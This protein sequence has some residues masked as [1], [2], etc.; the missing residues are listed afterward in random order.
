CKTF[1]KRANG[2]VRSEGIGAA[3]FKP[4]NKALA[5]G[6][7]IYAVSKV[8]AENHGGHATSLTAPNPQAQ[9]QLL[10]SA[11]EKAHFDPSTI[12]YIEAHGTGTSLGDPIE[13]NALKNAFTELYKRSGKSLPTQPHCG[14]GSVKT[15]M[16]H[17]ESAAGMAGLFKVLLAMK[18][19]ILPGNLHFTE[20]N[21]YLQLQESPFYI[22]TENRAWIPLTDTGGNKIPRRAGVSSFGFG[23]SNA[24]IVLE[25][26]ESKVPSMTDD[27]PQLMVLSAKNTERL[28][29][30]ASSMI[31]FLAQQSDIPL[32][33]IAYTLQVGREAMVDRLA[34]VVSSVDEFF[35]KL[36]QYIQ[37][38]TEKKAFYC[39][40]VKTNKTQSELLIEGEEGRDFVHSIIKNKK[41]SKLAQLWVSG[42]EI[43]WQLF[44]ENPKPQRI[45]LPTYAFAKER[46]WIST[47]EQS[48]KSVEG[49]KAKFDSHES[50]TQHTAKIPSKIDEQNQW[51]V[52]KLEPG[53][54]TPSGSVLLFETDD[55][56]EFRFTVKTKL[57]EHSHTIVTDS[58]IL[59]REH[60]ETFRLKKH[61]QPPKIAFLFT[62]QGSQYVG[63]GRELY[64]TQPI[65]RQTL[66]RCDDILRAYLEKPL[67][68][69]LYQ[70]ADA[71]EERKILFSRGRHFSLDETI[72]TQPAL[73][74]LEYALVALWKSWGIEPT[75][76]MGHSLGEYVAACVAGVF[77]LE[78][79]LKL[80]VERARLMQSLPQEGEMM[81]VLADE[82]QVLKACEPYPDAVSIA[83]INEP[84][85][86]VISG[87]SQ[88][89]QAVKAILEAQGIETYRLNISVG[90]HSP[91]MTAILAD[92][93]KITSEV[94]YS[95]PQ[96]DIISNLT[97]KL[98]MPEEITTP[99]YWCRHAQQTVRFAAGI[100]TLAT[101]GIEIFL[102]IGPQPTLIDMGQHCLPETGVWL[103][104]L[105]QWA[106]NWQQ[107]FQSVAKLYV[108]GASIDWAAF[109]QYYPRCRV[110]LPI[111]LTQ[112]ASATGSLLLFDIDKVRYLHFKERLLNEVILVMPGEGYQALEPQIYSINPNHPADY[113]KLL[114]NTGLPSHIIHIGS[115]TPFDEAVQNAQLEM[116]L[117]SCV[118]LS[119]T[120][121][122][123]KPV[124]PIFVLYA[125]LVEPGQQ[126]QHVSEF[127]KT[128][129]LESELI[130][131]KTVALSSFDQIVDIV[132]SEFQ[133]SDVEIRYDK[134][135]RWVKQLPDFQSAEETMLDSV[136]KS[137][138]LEKVQTDLL[139]MATTQLKLNVQQIDWSEPLRDYGFNSIAL[140]EFAIRINNQYQLE[141][142]PAVFLEYP[143]VN[144]FSQFLCSK[145]Q[146][147]LI[148]YY[149]EQAESTS[150]LAQKGGGETV[151]KETNT[152]S[153]L[154][155]ELV[156]INTSGHYQPS[157]W[158]HGILGFANDFYRLAAILGPDYPV[159][160]FQARGLDG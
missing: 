101:Q 85:N 4:L 56:S 23:G 153:K 77:S 122:Q 34:M 102:E 7:K 140:T 57:P 55:K 91:L 61:R 124:E 144:A 78:D 127:V 22:V 115:P 152:R 5:D 150:V 95:S 108:Q 143:S 106:S 93:E 6:D 43:D 157:F 147:H 46:Y 49:Q 119:Q 72:Y 45:S 100:E 105:Q 2:Y 87:Q 41:L 36:T 94:N 71:K 158:V 12:S 52:S 73:F 80:V 25:E 53:L 27:S 79:G 1:D 83:A 97:G 121:L 136:E 133:T 145:Y 35:A 24:H 44:Y 69:V 32:F 66:E 111:N 9:A 113:Q 48:L 117:H 58:L 126:P 76:V 60:L 110:A 154:P 28:Q 141:I 54:L 118:H 114:A 81:T 74:A 64:Q 129:P 134:G 16:G 89:V 29:A 125:Y 90:A 135:Q 131:Y 75:V 70:E 138:L 19:K 148:A 38:K 120:L 98:V 116:G 160:A 10:I 62:G 139:N 123:Q 92:L 20:L 99:D 26:Y 40:N 68:E 159:Y 96:M 128:I 13:I 88:A 156:S 103:P 137:Q 109:G 21:P 37:G 149:Q 15:N 151:F 42:V 47:A 82:A 3:W 155:P 31:E 33:N 112:D 17:S 51:Q 104:S 50:V 30:Y 65:F 130:N 142:T 39:G 18:H 63:M 132:L 84:N 67:L 107:L 8:T 59:L 86:T 146:N 11:Y 14:L